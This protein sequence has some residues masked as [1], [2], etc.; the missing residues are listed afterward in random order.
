MAPEIVAR[1]SY[2]EKVDIWSL[3]VMTYLLLSGKPPFL[4]EDRE[5]LFKNIKKG[6][7][8]FSENAWQKI[9]PDC[10]DFVSQCLRVDPQ[11][12]PSAQFLLNTPW[13]KKY[14][15]E[16]AMRYEEEKSMVNELKYFSVSLES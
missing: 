6:E 16:E 12:R 15:K 9:S 7:V 8:S 13:I 2:D 1:K 10:Q 4:G 5:E 14:D 3:G 11:R